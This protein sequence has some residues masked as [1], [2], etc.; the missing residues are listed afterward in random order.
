M[1][2]LELRF[3]RRALDML[4][5]FQ[6]RNEQSAESKF[7]AVDEVVLEIHKLKARQQEVRQLQAVVQDRA[8]AFRLYLRS[9]LEGEQ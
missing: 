6:L 9:L 2:V 8:M 5:R 3:Q 4:F 7:F 1:R